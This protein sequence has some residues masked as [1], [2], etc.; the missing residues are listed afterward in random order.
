MGLVASVSSSHPTDAWAQPQE[1]WVKGAGEVSPLRCLE[2]SLK[3]HAS[4]VVA[5]KLHEN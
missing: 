3:I 4:R 5:K 2:K 1:Q